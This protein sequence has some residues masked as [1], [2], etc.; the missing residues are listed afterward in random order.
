MRELGE[1]HGIEYI[2]FPSKT[3]VTKENDYLN[4]A[5]SLRNSIEYPN[6]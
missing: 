6:E 3:V 4:D 5:N 2:P 1:K